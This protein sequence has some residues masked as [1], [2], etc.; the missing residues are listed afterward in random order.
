[1]RRDNEFKCTG[2]YAGKERHQTPGRQTDGVEGRSADR[3][4]RRPGSLTSG[5]VGAVHARKAK[6]ALQ[7]AIRKPHARA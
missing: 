2:L 5:T 3:V 7:S 4:D 1:M 6:H